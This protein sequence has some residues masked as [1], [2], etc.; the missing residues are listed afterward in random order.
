MVLK[1]RLVSSLRVIHSPAT[2]FSELSVFLNTLP[3]N[4]S[5]STALT[6]S[7]L[8][9]EVRTR[10]SKDLPQPWRR[11]L[12]MVSDNDTRSAHPPDPRAMGTKVLLKSMFNPATPFCQGLRKAEFFSCKRSNLEA[13]SLA[14]ALSATAALPIVS[15]Y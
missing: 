3:A 15:S 4:F 6:D 9:M 1:I 8:A 2:Y 12:R 5:K 14:S 7:C 11:V 10:D 13:N